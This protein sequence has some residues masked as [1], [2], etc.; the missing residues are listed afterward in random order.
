MVQSMAKEIDIIG[1]QNSQAKNHTIETIYFG[2]GTPSILLLQEIEWLLTNM[3]SAFTV[4]SN[5]EVT[6]EANPD[7]INLESLLHW[8]KI[9]INRLSVG[10]QSF[11]Q[12]ELQWMNRAHTAEE[13]LHCI[14]LIRKAGFTNFSIDLIYGSPLLTN[15]DWIKNVQTIIEKKVPH[16]SCYALTVE[17][18]TALY[19]QIKKHQIATVDGEKQADQFLLLMDMM[20]QHGYNHY[21]ISNYCIP[22]FESKHN[23]SYWQNKPYF[24]IGPSAHSFDGKTRKWNVANNALYC[25]LAKKYHPL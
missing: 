15:E 19:N 22:G 17:P 9:G 6:L 1:Y 2:G 23:S 4:L 14:D 12:A 25:C 8:K 13:S 3:Y 7:D 10:I 16:V 20:E 24:A 11:N 21:E 5:A 18:K